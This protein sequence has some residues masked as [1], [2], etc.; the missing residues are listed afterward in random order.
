MLFI[1]HKAV[2]K[3]IWC[4]IVECESERGH[5]EPFVEWEDTHHPNPFPTFVTWL[6]HPRPPCEIFTGRWHD[7]SATPVCCV[8]T[9]VD[10]VTRR[11]HRLLQSALF[12]FRLDFSTVCLELYSKPHHQHV[13]CSCGGFI[14]ASR[15]FSHTCVEL[16]ATNFLCVCVCV[17]F[18]QLI[19][20][21]F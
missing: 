6:F 20:C 17:W 1:S 5:R 18:E 11:P 4:T 16:S 7:T 3:V 21:P 8:F 13:T 9:N 14:R 19:C 12:F 15:A 10:F 2:S